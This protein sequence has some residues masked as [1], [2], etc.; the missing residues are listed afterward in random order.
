MQSPDKT[1]QKA[2]GKLKSG[3]PGVIDLIGRLDETDKIAA[4]ASE[5]TDL[6]HKY[7]QQEQDRQDRR[8]AAQ[9]EREIKAD[10]RHDQLISIL[11]QLVA[12]I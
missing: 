8:D 1:V 9:A 6:M 4:A 11:G 2:G 5:S 3:K 10:A 7:M 12:K